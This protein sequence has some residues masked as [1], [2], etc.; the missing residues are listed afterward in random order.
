M[1]VHDHNILVVENC[2]VKKERD[3]E[4]HESHDVVV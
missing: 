4:L 3:D 1:L 2:C